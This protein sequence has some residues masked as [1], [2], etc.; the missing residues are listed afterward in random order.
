MLDDDYDF[1]ENTIFTRKL[2]MYLQ[3]MKMGNF[4]PKN[5][6]LLYLPKIDK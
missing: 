4:K 3:W 1:A 6:L 2:Y 5:M